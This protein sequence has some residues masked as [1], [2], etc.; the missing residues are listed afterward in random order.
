VSEVYI[1][2]GDR[3]VKE[4]V[5]HNQQK[6]IDELQEALGGQAE[7]INSQDKKIDHLCGVI[8]QINFW[9]KEDAKKL[10]NE[11]QA[12]KTFSDAL[13]EEKL[14]HGATEKKLAE[15]Q[16]DEDLLSK[17]YLD[18][19]NHILELEKEVKK[20]NLE[21]DDIKDRSDV[22][23]GKFTYDKLI[24]ASLCKDKL[25][26]AVNY[27]LYQKDQDY[28][29]ES[30]YDIHTIRQRKVFSILQEVLDEVDRIEMGDGRD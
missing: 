25:E 18:A 14:K 23:L 26:E 17:N 1:I 30:V 6:K 21:L 24:R 19:Q 20:L 28:G 22:M 16:S 3:Y 5:Y 27:A 9:R 12:T 13:N 11:R 4:W 7:I 15:L 29:M 8:D 2:A 10:E